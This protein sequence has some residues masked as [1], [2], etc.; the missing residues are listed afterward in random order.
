FERLHDLWEAWESW[1]AELEE[2]HTSLPALV[3]FRSPRPHHSWVTAAGTVLDSAAVILAAVDI[4]RDTQ[5]DLCIRA[6]YI[7]LRHI[8]VY[9][10]QAHER[11]RSARANAVPS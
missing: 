5:A 7:A 3:F 1:F 4:P 8:A 2:T 9:S 6:G 11:P 10:R